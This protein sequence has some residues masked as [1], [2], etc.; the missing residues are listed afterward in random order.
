VGDLG[1]DPGYAYE[2]GGAAATGLVALVQLVV[3]GQ[4]QRAP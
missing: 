2:V 1:V 4:G 3:T